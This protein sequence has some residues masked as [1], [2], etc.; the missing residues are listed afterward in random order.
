MH[1]F[2]LI[3]ALVA[4]SISASSP[5]SVPLDKNQEYVCV[6]WRG[7]ADYTQHQPSVCLKW[8]VKEKP[9]VRRV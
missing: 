9:L 4:V 1:T 2:Y 5:Q 7:S 6:H 8:E 3:V